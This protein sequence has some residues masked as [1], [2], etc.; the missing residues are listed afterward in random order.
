[1]PTKG[2]SSECVPHQW[3]VHCTWKALHLGMQAGEEGRHELYLLHSEPI[4][5]SCSVE[6]TGQK[7]PAFCERAFSPL[8]F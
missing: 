2:M 4:C 5:S 1:M 7:G 8:W 6:R 3:L